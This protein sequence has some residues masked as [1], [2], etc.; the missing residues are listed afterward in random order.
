MTRE[1]R[2]EAIVR[3]LVERFAPLLGSDLRAVLEEGLREEARVLADGV[4]QGF[5]EEDL[6]DL[7]ARRVERD[8]LAVGPERR[9]EVLRGWV[10]ARDLVVALEPL[11]LRARELVRE[12]RAKGLTPPLK[13]EAARL[14]DEVVGVA[15]AAPAAAVARERATIQVVL[16][17]CANVLADGLLGPDEGVEVG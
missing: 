13:A 17:N 10:A 3:P 16:A 5:A 4:E 15:R 7:L 8:V 2:V 9:G 11:G 1:A 14:L 12:H 6:R